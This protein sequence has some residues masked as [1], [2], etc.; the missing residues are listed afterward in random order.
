MISIFWLYELVARFSTSTSAVD[1]STAT[2]VEEIKSAGYNLKA[3]TLASM[4]MGDGSHD[5]LRLTWN[6]STLQKIKYA[7][8]CSQTTHDTYSFCLAAN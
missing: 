5:Q 4:I 6:A 2:L 8:A 3:F 1:V 7:M